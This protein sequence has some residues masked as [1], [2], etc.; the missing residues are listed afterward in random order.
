MLGSRAGDNNAHR[1]KSQV[2]QMITEEMNSKN[3][4]IQRTPTEV[5]KKWQNLVTSARKELRE[6]E[7]RKEIIIFMISF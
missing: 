3:P 5:R 7:Q 4:S 2:W 1:M 6:A